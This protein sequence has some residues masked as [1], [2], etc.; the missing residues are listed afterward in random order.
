MNRY[1]FI[2]L[3]FGLSCGQKENQEQ[4]GTTEE[5]TETLVAARV[6]L[7]SFN[8]IDGTR[9][10]LSTVGIGELGKWRDDEMG[11]FMSITNYYTFGE[12]ELNN[13]AYYLESDNSDYVTTLKLVLN[14]NN[15]SEK[16]Q[17]LNKLTEVA[18]K[19]FKVLNLDFPGELQKAIKKEKPLII[20]GDNF[21]SELKLEKSKI[22]TWTIKITTK[23]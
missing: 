18:E 19:T 21:T 4:K 7:E 3:L 10:K 6:K 20:D 22:D 15:K 12:N 13:L 17:A 2:I 5:K 1:I 8:D 16:G 23:K 11:G 9:T 14:I